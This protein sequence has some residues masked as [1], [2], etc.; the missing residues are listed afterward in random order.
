M[1]DE[2]GESLAD[3]STTPD[4]SLHAYGADR[5][6]DIEGDAEKLRSNDPEDQKAENLE[7]DHEDEIGINPA[8]K[9]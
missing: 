7:S 3:E 1:P 5:D 4:S 2:H 9:H 6:K 8:E